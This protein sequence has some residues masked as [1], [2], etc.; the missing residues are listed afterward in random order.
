MKTMNYNIKLYE[1]LP[2]EHYI[3]YVFRQISHDLEYKYQK[4][5]ASKDST[6]FLKI[7]NFKQ[8]ESL[9]DKFM[10]FEISGIDLL[11]E[12]I[13]N[14]GKEYPRRNAKT[15]PLYIK[16][17]REIEFEKVEFGIY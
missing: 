9:G 3:Q 2:I 6:K 4:S 5:I 8:F 10:W 12:Y 7:I 14:F 1:K 15:I 13:V 17:G 16:L 11:E